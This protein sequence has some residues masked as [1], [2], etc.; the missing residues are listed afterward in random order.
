V[1]IFLIEVNNPTAGWQVDLKRLEELT[2]DV[3]M[4]TRGLEAILHY[5]QD[6]NKTG[7]A[8]SSKELDQLYKLLPL[9][10]LS[11]RGVPEQSVTAASGPIF[12]EPGEEEGR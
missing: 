8:T 5:I 1:K 3:Q 9:E 10:W 12:S 11:S 4:V 6:D 2:G 7:F